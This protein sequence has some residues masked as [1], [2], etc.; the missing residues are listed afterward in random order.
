[1]P[2]ELKGFYSLDRN[3]YIRLL[4]HGFD[5][6]HSKLVVAFWYLVDQRNHYKFM[7][8]KIKPIGDAE[9]NELANETL[10]CLICLITDSNISR[11][12]EFKRLCEAVPNFSL[13]LGNKEKAKRDMEWLVKE[14]YENAFGDIIQQYWLNGLQGTH[15]WPRYVLPSPAAKMANNQS[16]PSK[17][18][19]DWPPEERSLFFTFS[20][21]HPVSREELETLIRGW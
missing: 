19:I 12:S 13:V 7:A 9:F 3:I 1:M 4:R 20:K 6:N 11:P 5:L 17:Q 15:N 21:G 2:D 18:E 16:F 14:V 8:E 10:A